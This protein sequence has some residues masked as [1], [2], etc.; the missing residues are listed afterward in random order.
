MYTAEQKYQLLQCSKYQT[1]QP[2]QGDSVQGTK[3]EQKRHGY[4]SS[5]SSELKYPG[6]NVYCT[7]SSMVTEYRA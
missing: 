6:Y 2:T 7:C 4:V 1:E 5:V 3:A